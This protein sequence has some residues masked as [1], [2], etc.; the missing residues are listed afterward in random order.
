MQQERKADGRE[1]KTS[2][3][4]VDAQS[5]KNTDTAQE[6]GYDAGKKVS[7]IKRHI[8]VDTNGLPH[9]ILVTTANVSDRAGAVAM[10]LMNDDTLSSVVNILVDGA[11]TGENFAGEVKAILGATVEVAKRSEL[12]KFAVIPKR[13]VVERSFAWLEKCRRLWKNCERKLHTSEQFIVL[14]FLFVLIKR[15]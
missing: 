7:G 9:A 14:A 3:G 4:I 1:E 12:H 15:H 10:F 2:F 6:K 8:T 5:V 13:W 11:Y